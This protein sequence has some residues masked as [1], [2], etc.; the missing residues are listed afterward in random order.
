MVRY[1]ATPFFPAYVSG[2]STYSSAA[3]EV[4]P[5]LFPQD[6]KFW[7]ARAREAGVSRLLGGIHWPIDNR[8]GN[9]MGTKI[10]RLV[11]GR[12]KRDGAQ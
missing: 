7:R 8:E 3:G 1:L 9:R 2:H 4:L 11:V 6:A 12:A 10:G 5:H